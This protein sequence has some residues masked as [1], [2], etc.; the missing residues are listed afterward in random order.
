M[1][2]KALPEP[3]SLAGKLDLIPGVLSLLAAGFVAATTGLWRTERDAPAY[4]VHAAY[5]L[6]R[7]ST[8]RY[9]LAQLQWNLPS[10]DQVYEQYARSARIKPQT[11]VLGHGAKG[12]RVGDKNAKNVLIWYHG[13]CRAF[14]CELVWR[15]PGGGFGMAANITFFEFWEKL[16][17]SAR[18]KNKDLAVFALS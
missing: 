15:K 11:V 8:E 3:L 9:S 4:Y 5:A 2:P 16:I 6:L 13:T 1:S 10:T 7:K 12:H 14:P 18:T 17:V